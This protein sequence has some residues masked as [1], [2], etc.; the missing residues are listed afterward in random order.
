M[1]SILITCLKNI[2]N[3][4]AVLETYYNLLLRGYWAELK[5]GLKSYILEVQIFYS[6][7]H[8]RFGTL[9]TIKFFRVRNL[10][11][12]II[13]ALFA[14][15]AWNGSF[16]HDEKVAFLITDIQSIKK[17]RVLWKFT[18]LLITAVT[19]NKRR[20]TNERFRLEIF[21]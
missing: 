18:S 12:F 14:R 17:V 5:E 10:N 19:I 3:L 21:S 7:C 20:Y 2:G 15:K 4:Q 6:A 13:T 16:W 1:L 8:L 11:K 9:A